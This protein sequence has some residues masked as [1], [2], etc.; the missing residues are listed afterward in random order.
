[1]K[2]G[3][4][5]AAY[6]NTEGGQAV[7]DAYVSFSSFLS[8]IVEGGTHLLKRYLN[9]S[10]WLDSHDKMRLVLTEVKTLLPKVQLK[11]SDVPSLVAKADQ[12]IAAQDAFWNMYKTWVQESLVSAFDCG[13]GL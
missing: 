1:M 6:P 12:L 13:N 8:D 10:Q 11:K 4:I 7:N 3:L 9:G 5:D 2:S